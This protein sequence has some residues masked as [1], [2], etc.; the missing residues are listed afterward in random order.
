MEAQVKPNTVITP[1]AS[2]FKTTPM[3]ATMATDTTTMKEVAMVEV[4]VTITTNRLFM[5]D[6]S[7]SIEVALAKSKYR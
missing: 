4:E 3:V 5:A 7:L 1:D 2:P 6:L